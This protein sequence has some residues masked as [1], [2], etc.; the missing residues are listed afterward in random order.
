MGAEFL[1]IDLIVQQCWKLIQNRQWFSEVQ[2]FLLFK[3]A[4]ECGY[5][6]VQRMAMQ[7]VSSFF[8]TVVCSLDCVTLTLGEVMYMLQLDNIAVNSEIDVFY[9]AAR[10]LLHDWNARKKHQMEVMQN[11]RFGL[12]DSSRIVILR[13]NESCGRL[14]ELLRNKELQKALKEALNYAIY[15]ERFETS[16]FPVFENFLIRFGYTRLFERRLIIDP[17]WQERHERLLYSFED[18]INYLKFIKANAL[19]HW[20]SLKSRQ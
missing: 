5:E 6:K 10:W 3:E 17:Y 2:A 13:Q 20:T 1:Q 12:I 4:R 14:S 15:R 9:A 16:D 18:F 7:E 8:L 11:I 19:T